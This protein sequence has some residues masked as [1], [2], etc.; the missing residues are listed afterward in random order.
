MKLDHP[1]VIRFYGTFCTDKAIYFVMELCESGNLYQKMGESGPFAESEV[2]RIIRQV[3]SALDYLHNRNII[4]RDI[5][6]ENIVVHDKIVK[7]CDFG[8]ASEG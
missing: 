2:R 4:H 6:A 8:W 5:K 3:C 7:I 1:N